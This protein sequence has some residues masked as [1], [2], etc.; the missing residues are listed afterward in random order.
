VKI[1][2]EGKIGIILVVTIAL[3]VWGL[4]F[5]KGNDIFKKQRV[6]Y[7]VYER[8][9]GLVAS[10]PV[11]VS[12]MKI[13]QVSEMS[14]ISD[15]VPLIVV[16]FTIKSDI[17]IPSNTI[18]R[19]YSQD[20]MGSKAIGLKLGKSTEMANVGDTLMTEIEAGLMEEVNKQVE[21]IK[22][23]A[24]TLLA[25]I[26]SLV[27]I[28]QFV[29]NEEMRENLTKSVESIRSTMS[30]FETTTYRLDTFVTNEENR[31]SSIIRNIELISENLNNNND[32]ISNILSNLSAV[33][34]TLANTDISTT[35]K[36]TNQT[37][38]DISS[39]LNKI[40]E[41][42]GTLGLLIND[43]S[44]YNRLLGSSSE[45]NALLEDVKLNPGRYVH[46]S[47][48]GKKDSKRP[49]VPPGEE[50]ET[51]KRKKKKNK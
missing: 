43:D 27:M 37:L 2:K 17:V 50:E 19:I 11:N 15:S 20:I 33:T 21:P 48:F 44:L 47:M 7:A 31:L 42:E 34:D 14:F 18:A 6:Y 28:I 24:E 45:L 38:Q 13:G 5:L 25:S 10:N 30:N 1:S 9:D 16:E 29:F 36:N 35:L 22:K 46:V 4:N 8:V 23:K 41:G 26:D 32:N 39:I 49:Y 40:E 51:S 12:G 3:L